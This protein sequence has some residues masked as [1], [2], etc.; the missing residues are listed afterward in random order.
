M[1][2]QFQLLI[3]TALLACTLLP[4]Y[5]DSAGLH[6]I[7]PVMDD[8]NSD[9]TAPRWL[10]AALQEVADEGSTNLHTALDKFLVDFQAG[11]AEIGTMLTQF[12]LKQRAANERRDAKLNDIASAVF[13]P[14]FAEHVMQCARSSTVWLVCDKTETLCSGAVVHHRGR[15]LT[16]SAGHCSCPGGTWTAASL[17]LQASSFPGGFVPRS[18]AV[19]ENFLAGEASAAVDGMV[20][21]CGPPDGLVRPLS[22][23]AI[24]PR[25]QQTLVYA[26]F[27]AGRGPSDTRLALLTAYSRAGKAVEV[28][29]Q[30]VTAHAAVSFSNAAPASTSM[31][32]LLANG[33]TATVSRYDAFTQSGQ[34]SQGGMSGGP[35]LTTGC[36][37]VG[38]VRG[39]SANKQGV[40]VPVQVL[41]QMYDQRH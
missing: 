4:A 20:L 26:G 19:L 21:D 32:V 40:Y 37:L 14:D 3:V 39:C 24:E 22:I 1:R 34:V 35:V 8:S 36:E 38:L 6:D 17:G 41:L 2:W 18:C 16:L 9:G 5:A 25:R 27:A 10:T 13:S 33:G 28:F 7:M 12:V 15:S 11:T 29:L 31:S 30:T 23:A